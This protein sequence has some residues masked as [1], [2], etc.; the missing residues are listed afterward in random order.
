MFY[1]PCSMFY[2]FPFHNSV[3]KGASFQE[4]SRKNT[5]YLLAKNKEGFFALELAPGILKRIARICFI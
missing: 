2:S 4:L 1:V 5:F 3:R